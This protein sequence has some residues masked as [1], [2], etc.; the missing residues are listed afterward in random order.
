MFTYENIFFDH[1]KIG[2][3]V[4]ERLIADRIASP[5]QM[6]L[7]I[8]SSDSHRGRQNISEKSDATHR[9]FLTT[10]MPSFSPEEGQPCIFVRADGVICLRS[11]YG[12]VKKHLVSEAACILNK[13]KARKE[14]D[15]DVNHGLGEA[16]KESSYAQA[17]QQREA[18]V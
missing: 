7:V 4:K 18:S 3:Y 15:N 13:G 10:S 1:I 9:V 6:H 5:D 2:A 8:K 16:V 17:S 12:W 14:V 11:F